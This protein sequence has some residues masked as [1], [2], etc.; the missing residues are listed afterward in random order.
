[1]YPTVSRP[2]YTQ[3]HGA[4]VNAANVLYG[5][6]LNIK[7]H[8][9]SATDEIDR[10]RDYCYRGD[11]NIL[12]KRNSENAIG[13]DP[14]ATLKWLQEKPGG[15]A[16]FKEVID[17]LSEDSSLNAM[18]KLNI[19]AKLESRVKDCLADVEKS[20]EGSHFEMDENRI[21]MIVWQKKGIAAIFSPIFMKAKERLKE[22]LDP[23]KIVYA[24]GLTAGEISARCRLVKVTPE[25]TFAEDDL[26]KQDRQTDLDQINI[27]MRIYVE[28][29]GVRPEVIKIWRRAHENWTARNMNVRIKMTGMRQTGQ[30]TTALGNAITNL[31][32][33]SRLIKKMG[34]ALKLMLLL[35]DDNVIICNTSITE[36]DIKLNSGSY[37][38]M[39]SKP[40]VSGNH[41]GFLRMI[42]YKSANGTIECGPDFVRLRRRYELTNGVNEASPENMAARTKS[43]CM[44]LGNLSAVENLVQSKGYGLELD[45]W[46]DYSSV[47]NAL[48]EKYRMTESE[49]DNNV[50]QLLDMMTNQSVYEHKKLMFVTAK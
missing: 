28:H 7:K 6:T 42:L 18:N 26:E 32:V 34:K 17:I 45:M 46:Y 49:V 2:A 50:A 25:T 27:E 29:L 47:V 8:K 13:F 37:Y 5:G 39:I 44:M 19:H 31:V 3:R 4:L 10:V 20:G 30:A 14:E 43:Y 1:M 40:Y 24:D 9:L 38:N 12:I 22:L 48:C 35:G 23:G 11:C 33:K 15:E 21:R 16:T 41:G 36:E